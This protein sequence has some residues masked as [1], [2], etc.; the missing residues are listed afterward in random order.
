M[1]LFSTEIQWPQ[2]QRVIATFHK[3]IKESHHPED[4][5]KAQGQVSLSNINDAIKQPLPILIHSTPPMEYWQFILKGY[6]RGSSKT[7]CH[8][9]R[10]HKSTLA[11]IFIQYSLGSSRP[12]LQS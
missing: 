2:Y 8:V 5:I 11:T 1:H 10:L 7:I 6:S 12:V 3:V 4:F 9:S